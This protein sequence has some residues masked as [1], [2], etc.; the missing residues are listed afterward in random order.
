MEAICHCSASKTRKHYKI[1]NQRVNGTII[2]N[3]NPKTGESHKESWKWPKEV[4]PRSIKSL[5]RL[6]LP[7]IESWRRETAVLKCVFALKCVQVRSDKNL[8]HVFVD[9]KFS[10]PSNKSSRRRNCV[11]NKIGQHNTTNIFDYI[12]LAGKFSYLRKTFRRF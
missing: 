5:L 12:N 1:R 4:S 11:L 2:L 9:E 6:S 7:E 3:T 10:S 8:T